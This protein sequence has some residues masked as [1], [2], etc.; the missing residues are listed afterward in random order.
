MK[1]PLESDPATAQKRRGDFT[2][3]FAE[4]L[5]RA[6]EGGGNGRKE[7]QKAQKKEGT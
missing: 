5:E 1:V 2:A 4:K 3:E 7:A 6:A